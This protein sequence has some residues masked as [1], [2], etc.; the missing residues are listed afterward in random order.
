MPL[1]VRLKPN[2]KVIINGAVISADERTATTVVLHNRASVLRSRDIMQPDDA[3]TPAK[4]IYFQIMMMYIEP[5][6]KDT[7]MDDYMSFMTDLINMTTLDEVRTSLLLIYRDVSAGE[8]YRALKTCRAIIKL[9]DELLA[10]GQ[11]TAAE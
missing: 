2:E 1:K 5:E 6:N 9:E 7:F 10:I 3:T 4:R 8:L 11:Q